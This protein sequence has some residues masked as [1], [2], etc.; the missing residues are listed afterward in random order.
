MAFEHEFATW[1]RDAQMAWLKDPARVAWF[2]DEVEDPD[3]FEYNYLSDDRRYPV[4]LIGT[5][6]ARSL[7]RN[8]SFGNVWQ[9]YGSLDYQTMPPVDIPIAP[10]VN[11][12]GP[13]GRGYYRTPSL[14]GIWTSAPFLHNNALGDYNGDWTTEGRMEAYYDGME[15]LLGIRERPAKIAKTERFVALTTIPLG[16]ELPDLI[17]FID[18]DK[19]RLGLPVPTGTPI[20]A[21]ANLETPIL[22]LT[23]ITLLD[24]V[25]F[26]LNGPQA[27]M[28]FFQGS[29]SIFDPVENKGHEF[30]HD[31]TEAE[32]RALIEFLK[33]L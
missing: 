33:T 7:A 19:L 22:D 18:L 11:F 27:F 23:S 26:M 20:A 29:I 24:V 3:F 25:Y 17:P 8:A 2:V 6:S 10:G 15:K 13:M 30:G 28:D 1:D 31:R 16:F 9:E 12:E 32:K 14:W 21:I 5:N 4:S